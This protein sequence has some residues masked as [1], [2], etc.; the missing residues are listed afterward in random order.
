M[1]GNVKI[2][3]VDVEMLANAASPIFYKRLFHDDFLVQ[4]QDLQHEVTEDNG[5]M[6]IHG[7]TS[8]FGQMGFIMAKQA[9]MSDTQLLNLKIEDYIKWLSQFDPMALVNAVP[10]IT[11]LYTSQEKSSVEAKKK[12]D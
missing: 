8:I 5:A 7:D 12:D 6:L 2:G 4:L 11:V 1:R 9:E 10:D 3:S